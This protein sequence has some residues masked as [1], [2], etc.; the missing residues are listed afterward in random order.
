M[1]NIMYLCRKLIK[2]FDYKVFD[3]AVNEQFDKLER[4]NSLLYSTHLTDSTCRF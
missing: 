2:D 1:F 4:R 3:A